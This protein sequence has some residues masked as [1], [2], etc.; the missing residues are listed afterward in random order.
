MIPHTVMFDTLTYPP[1]IAQHAKRHGPAESFGIMDHVNACYCKSLPKQCK[2]IFIKPRPGHWPSEKTLKQAKKLGVFILPQG[3]PKSTNICTYDYF[4]YHWRMSTNLTER[5][6]MFSLDKVHLKSYVLTK[7]IRKE[8]FVPEYGDRLSTFHFKTAF[9]FAVE[10]TPPDVWID[11]NLINCVKN[12]LTTLR[13]FLTRRNC[14]HFTIENV[15]LFD[16]KFERYEFPKLVDRLTFVINSL[17]TK[18]ENIQLDGIGQTLYE[19]SAIKHDRGRYCSNTSALFVFV[20]NMCDDYGGVFS[21]PE[22]PVYFWKVCFENIYTGLQTYYRTQLGKYRKY[23]LQ[24]VMSP[25]ASRGASAYLKQKAE[26]RENNDDGIDKARHMFIQTL[27]SDNISNYMRYSSFLF[28]NEEYDEACKYFEL[29]EDLIQ[30]DKQSNLVYQLCVSPSES[31]ALQIAKQSYEKTSKQK[32]SVFLIFSKEEAMCVP[33]FLRYEMFL[34]SFGTCQSCE[35]G[36]NM[37]FDNICVQI[38]PYLYYLQ[39]L[40]YRQLHQEPKQCEALMKLSI[41]TEIVTSTRFISSIH[42]CLLARGYLNTSLNML[43]HCFELEN[44]L[45][46]AWKTYSTSLRLKP[47]RNASALHTTRLLWRVVQS[48]RT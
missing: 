22:V 34:D 1:P 19:R 20:F 26:C 25:L 5:L 46:T 45:E 24:T 15:N 29:I 11:N 40:T 33:V 30:G 23:E 17:R 32:R 3:P 41:F 39:Y 4:D 31:L 36:L 47:E 12:I 28:C 48:L 16:G 35:V 9:F 18:I 27:D 7:I 37:Y 38:E 2:L 21:F 10:N 43:G 14:P 42:N 6:L 8:L 44:K 13:R